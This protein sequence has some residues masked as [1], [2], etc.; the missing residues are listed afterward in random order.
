[1]LCAWII[2]SFA[3]LNFFI[4]FNMVDPSRHFF[5]EL[6]SLGFLDRTGV[7]SNTAFQRRGIASIDY[8]ENFIII[9]PLFPRSAFTHT[10]NL[11]LYLLLMV[12]LMISN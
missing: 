2:F 11:K 9:Y 12:L 7:F 1:M 8:I 3:L 5:L 6:G 10:R 4:I